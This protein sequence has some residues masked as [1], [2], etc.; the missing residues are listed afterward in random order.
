MGGERDEEQ[1]EVKAKKK[2]IRRKIREKE[3]KRKREEAYIPER[4]GHV[5]ER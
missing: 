4:L 1:A 2:E 5:L 3:S